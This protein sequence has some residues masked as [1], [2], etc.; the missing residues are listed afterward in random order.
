MAGKYETAISIS[1]AI[2]NI[3]GG[4]YLL[5]AIQRKFVWNS[6]Q[7]CSL[8]D[9][10]MRDYPIN[11]FMMWDIESAEIKN[12]YKFYEFLK[13]YC[14]RF[15]E[16]NPHRPT[17]ANTKDFKAVIDGQQRLTSLYI[18]LC[19]TYAYKQPRKHWPHSKNDTDLPP[20]KLYLDLKSPADSDDESMM[21]YNF[22][23]LTDAQYESW[24]EGERVEYHWFCLHDIL[25]M[26]KE[27]NM[28]DV[29]FNIVLP[30]VKKNNLEEN[31]FS[32]KT[33]ARLYKV[34]R[35]DSVIHYFNETSQEIDHVLDVFIRTNS[36]GTKLDFSDLLMSIAVASWDGDFR[37][38]IDD[39]IKRIYQSQEMGF[40][41]GRDWILKTCLMLVGS[42][43]KFKVR[44]FNAN[45]VK[46][47]QQSW[48]DIK[49][50]IVASFK[51]VNRLGLNEQS[52]TSRNAVMPI[53]YYLYSK[54][55]D[56]VQLYKVINSLAKQPE[57][58]RE[59]GKW[60]YMALLKG[61]FGGQAD[62]ILSSMRQ[63]INENIDEELFPLKQIIDRYKVGNKDL[64]FT[65]EYIEDL[66][67]TQHGDNRC[68]ALLLL[69]FPE[70]NE[71]ETLHIDH[72]HPQTE[73]SKNKL[74]E[75]TFLKDNEELHQFYLDPKKWNSLANLHPLNASLNSS[76]NDMPLDLWI[77]NSNNQFDKKSLLIGESVSL[78]FEKFKTF[79]FSRREALKQ[80]LI[81][82][83]YLTETLQDNELIIDDP[84]SEIVDELITQ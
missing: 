80:R 50:C 72:L 57:Q 73:F 47:I 48:N 52:L 58:R 23:F 64:R 60:L 77:E 61:V 20:R 33:L 69:M 67:N 70:R 66:L 1:K 78:D 38:E 37:Q 24:V 62:T 81:S 46:L 7:I 17:N 16:E 36:G 65:D 26:K 49:E 68:R 83:V 75:R 53:V 14:K 34:I 29:L 54:K 44:N 10:L 43:V 74:G 84:D 45:Q 41:I 42:D 82:R 71:A 3:D 63:V 9:S 55:N 76:K 59:I 2:Q 51:L 40:Y 5:P 22:R 39:L 79:Y 8:F 56:G 15:D 21:L 27:E 32:R 18:G 31:E 13:F 4:D 12:H 35:N 25:K 28:D 30:Y 19:G 11:T 6:Q